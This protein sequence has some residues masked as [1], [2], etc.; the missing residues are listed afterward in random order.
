MTQMSVQANKQ[1]C[2]QHK[3]KGKNCNNSSE[4]LNTVLSSRKSSVKIISF[5]P[6]P[7]IAKINAEDCS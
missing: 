1:K 2:S 5:L 4:L 3:K 7:L 6:Q